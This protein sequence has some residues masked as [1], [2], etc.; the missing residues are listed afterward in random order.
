MQKKNEEIVGFKLL[1]IIVFKPAI[2]PMEYA[3][4]SPKKI[5]ALGKLNNKND[6]KIIIWE[7]IKIENSKYPLFILMYANIIFIIIKLIVSKPLKPSIKLA[8]LITNRK[9]RST[10]IEENRWLDIKYVKNGISILRIFMGSMYMEEKSRS[11]IITNL[12]NGLMLILKSSKK[13]IVNT[14]QLIKI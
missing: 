10:N 4:L 6:N 13:P 2:A 3:P 8:P 14:E 9:Q 11:I 1:V 7:I 5:F 12:L